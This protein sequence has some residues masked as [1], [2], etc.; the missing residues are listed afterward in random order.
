MK[1]VVIVCGATINDYDF[2][3][4]FINK[5][6]FFIYCDSGLKHIDGL[7]NAGVDIKLKADECLIVGDF[8]SHEKPDFEAETIVLPRAKDDTDSVYAIKTA[9]S[10]GYDEFVLVGAIGNRLDHSLVNVY[11]LLDLYKK[12]VNAIAIDDY[13]V[14]SVVGNKETAFISKEWSYFSLIAINGNAKGV[15]IKNAKFNLSNADINTTYQYA[16]SNEVAGD[17]DA[18]VSVSEGNLLLIKV[19][20]GC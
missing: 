9:L 18:E 16:S 2:V 10:K 4:S 13:S 20:S 19:R 11:A 1:R 3:A 17:E 8:D 6:D 14:M 12:N 7:R 5:N 15:T